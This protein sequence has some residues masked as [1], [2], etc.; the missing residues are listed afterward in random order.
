MERIEREA[1]DGDVA[2]WLGVGV[3]SAYQALHMRWAVR[4][5]RGKDVYGPKET[6]Y[7]RISFVLTGDSDWVKRFICAL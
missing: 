7:G 4:R 3:V 6:A 5:R 1:V 2:G